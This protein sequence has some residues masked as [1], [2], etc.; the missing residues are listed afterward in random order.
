MSRE[1]GFSIADIDSGFVADPKVVA[2]ARRLHDQNVTAA[3]CLLYL[4]LVLASWKAGK[5]LTLDEG[6]PAW[7]TDSLDDARG[8][9]EAVDLLDVDGRIHDRAWEGWFG[10]ASARREERREAGRRGGHA[11][12]RNQRPASSV[13]ARPK[14]S[15]NGNQAKLYPTVPTGPTGSNQRDG[16][17]PPDVAEEA[18][19]SPVPCAACGLLVA[20]GDKSTWALNNEAQVV[21][22]ACLTTAKPVASLI[23]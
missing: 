20:A 19:P 5:R 18:D 21:H 23:S 1:A 22:R 16:R 7:W 3:Y 9:L 14:Q 15:H 12:A 17:R 6:A 11:K 8:H 2:L 10:P 4:S 13:V